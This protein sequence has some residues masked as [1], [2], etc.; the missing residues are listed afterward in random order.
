MTPN[1]LIQR[2]IAEGLITFKPEPPKVT[3]RPVTKRTT[4]HR[5]Q[6]EAMQRLRAT[7]KHPDV[8]SGKLVSVRRMAD[9][10]FENTYRP[11]IAWLWW[12]RNKGLIPSVKIA[13]RVYFDVDRVREAV[14]TN[15]GTNHNH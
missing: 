1:P 9:I 10:L 6:R 3:G 2:A 5:K 11:Q 7:P 14:D 13:G 12:A 15:F 4:R 8:F